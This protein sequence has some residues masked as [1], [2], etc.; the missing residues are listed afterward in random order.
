MWKPFQ[1]FFFFRLVKLERNAFVAKQQSNSLS[2]SFDRFNGRLASLLNPSG[3][4][5]TQQVLSL[6]FGTGNHYWM[7][8]ST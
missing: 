3:P 8:L 1:S 5:C 6:T 2:S 4:R 7:D